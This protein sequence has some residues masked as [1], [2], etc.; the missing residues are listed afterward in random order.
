MAIGAT[1]V[2]EARTTATASNVNGGFYTSGG[3][4]FSQQDAAQF[5]T[6]TATSAGAGAVI[7]WAAAASSMV[8]NGL[9]VVSGTNFTAGWYEVISVSVG[10]S[11]T[12]DRA[13]T[14]GAGSNGVVN[15]GGALSLGSSD[16]AVFESMV[17]GNKMYVKNGT[18]TIGGTVS[19]TAAGS[20][21]K[22]IEII[23]Y[24]SA[25]DDNPT[26]SSRPIFDCGTAQWTFAAFWRVKYLQFTSTSASTVNAGADNHFIDCKFSCTSGTANRTAFTATSRV[27]CYKC[28]F[29]S[30]AGYGAIGNAGQFVG[31][32]FHDSVDCIRG[33]SAGNGFRCISCIFDTG[34]TSGAS[35]S[36]ACTDFQSFDSC[37][38]YGA[39]TPAGTGLLIAAGNTNVF[40]ANCIFYGWVTGISHGTA[41][42]TSCYDFNNLFFNNTTNATNW[43]TN[44]A[45]TG[46]NPQFTSGSGGNFA[47]GSVTAR[48]SGQPAIFPGA[49]ST[50]GPAVGAVQPAAAGSGG[51]YGF[52]G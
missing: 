27:I 8:G 49:L 13:V 42:Q 17:A 19:L 44:S 23:G 7:L 21:L 14:T 38:F 29:S 36:A 31:C 12:V 2:W 39:E 34:S 43:T 25:R 35:L 50:G 30:A 47:L 1:A 4:D 46:T 26:T 32:Y 40:V 3:T 11:V 33:T 24:N 51:N 22:D 9:R 20:S 15:V 48:I 28:E 45:I 6:T 5:S 52:I 37:T 16:D 18:Y 10:V 41:G